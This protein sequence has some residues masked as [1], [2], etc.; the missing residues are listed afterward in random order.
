MKTI[1][2]HICTVSSLLMMVLIIAGCANTTSSNSSI[3]VRPSFTIT[4]DG[5]L[6][7][8]SQS[9]LIQRADLI[10]IGTILPD[11]M[12]KW[13]TPTGKLPSNITDAA[14]IPGGLFIYTHTP[15]QVESYLKGDIKD[16]VIMVQTIGGKV[17]SDQML[18]ESQPS[19]EP[20]QKVLLFLSNDT[21]NTKDIPSPHY[22]LTLGIATTYY[23][24]N[25]QADSI[26]GTFKLDD[27]ITT[28]SEQK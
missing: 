18:T 23:I 6:P 14:Q 10:V 1:I 7:K 24:T 9:E 11:S 12:S 21:V 15:I 22:V 3:P 20:N 2:K 13:N 4:V 28:I 5:S 27:L 16:T 19:F 25:D 17:D 8:F 26:D